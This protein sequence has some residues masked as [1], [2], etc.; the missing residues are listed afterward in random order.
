MKLKI[1]DIDTTAPSNIGV[2]HGSCEGPTLL[3]I[4]QAV[5]KTMTWPVAKPQLC[6][7]LNCS[8]WNKKRGVT[9][10]ELWA[11]L[12]ADDRVLLFNSGDDLKLG[13]NYLYHHLSKF[14]LLMHITAAFGALRST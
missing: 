7:N 9:V 2:R 13:A 3:F 10:Y 11:S 4:I 12:L 14:G 5:L 6:T 8:K 1:G